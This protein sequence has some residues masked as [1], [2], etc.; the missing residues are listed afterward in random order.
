MAGAAA[1]RCERESRQAK[2]RD[3]LVCDAPL[4]LPREQEQ[5]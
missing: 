2:G 1:I 3:G 4:L 5:D